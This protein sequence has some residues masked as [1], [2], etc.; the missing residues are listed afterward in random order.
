[1]AGERR[2]VH[3]RHSPSRNRTGPFAARPFRRENS[4]IDRRKRG[5]IRLIGWTRASGPAGEFREPQESGVLVEPISD[6]Q[7]AQWYPC[8]YRTALRLTGSAEDASDLTQEA[9]C[10]GLNSWGR[11]NGKSSPQTW[12]HAIL[13]NCIRD[14]RRR[15][16][17][18][19]ESS[20]DE[21]SITPVPATDDPPPA[22]LEHRERLTRLR[23][24]VQD[25]S[26]VLRA[27]FAATVLDGR[28]YREA[29]ELLSVPV[30]TVA[31][32]VHE[33]RATIRSE[34]RKAFPEA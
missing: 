1:M 16:A 11:F 26:P 29:A 17:S 18:R 13:L 20:L 22:R 12:L 27:A 24:A 34:M 10:R 14:W 6:Q 5:I 31:S 32:R 21:W 23:R 30:G 7:V 4:G 33:A 28:S 25:L 9:L 2:S 15:R 8:L 3:P 19:S